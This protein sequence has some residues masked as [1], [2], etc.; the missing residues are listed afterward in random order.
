MAGDSRAVLPVPLGPAA[1]WGSSSWNHIQPQPCPLLPLP[2]EHWGAN[3]APC[4]G[5]S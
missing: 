4:W 1:T 3:T 2:K 5:K